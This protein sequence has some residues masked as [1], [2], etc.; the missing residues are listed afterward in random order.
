MK[1]GHYLLIVLVL[2]VGAGVACFFWGK[3][4]KICPTEPIIINPV[5]PGRDARIDSLEKLHVFDLHRIDS[6]IKITK[7]P[8]ET[9]VNKP[10]PVPELIRELADY[11]GW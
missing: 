1:P 8:H 11:Y 5:D 2:A 9:I 3:S 6:L 4:D 7:R 10:L